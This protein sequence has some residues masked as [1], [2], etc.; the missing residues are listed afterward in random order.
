[1][2]FASPIWLLVL[3]AIPVLVLLAV[4]LRRREDNYA[5]RFPAAESLATAASDSRSVLHYAPSVLVLLGLTLLGLAL[6]KPQR[7]VKVPIEG[8]TVV[9]VLDHSGSMA[10]TDVEPTRLEAAVKAA[11]RFISKTPEKTRIGLVSYSDGP[12]QALQPTLSRE[13]IKTGLNALTPDGATATGSALQVA[14]TML[15]DQPKKNGS[16]PPSAIVLLSDGRRTVGSDPLIAAQQAR[17]QNVPISTVALGTP[18][19]TIP[20]PN[21]PTDRVPV[22]P[23]PETLSEI[24][25]ITGGRAFK[26]ED[27]DRLT[28]IYE[29]LGSTLATR[30]E[31]RDITEQLAAAGLLVLLIGALASVSL[32][33]RVP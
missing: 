7:E 32:A 21:D 23:D 24:A 19:A 10:A 12:D 4:R 17:E 33:G 30:T 25:S 11:E 29:S 9:L 31:K 26:A 14:L 13:P 20:N 6:G 22:P 18:G 28:S 15:Q 3:L 27:S 2:S 16:R 5:I 1:M 8:A